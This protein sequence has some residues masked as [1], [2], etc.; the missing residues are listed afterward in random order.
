MN[1]RIKAVI[2]DREICIVTENHLIRI[3]VVGKE[4]SIEVMRQGEFDQIG[5]M[6]LVLEDEL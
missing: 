5:E 1:A 3:N 4:V 2:A 6:T